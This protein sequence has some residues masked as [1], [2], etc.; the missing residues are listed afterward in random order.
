MYSATII[1]HKSF[2]RRSNS[3]K[4]FD[5]KKAQKVM[6]RQNLVVITHRLGK[7]AFDLMNN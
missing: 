1:I 2:L 6:I 7:K 5:E 3:Y 4:L